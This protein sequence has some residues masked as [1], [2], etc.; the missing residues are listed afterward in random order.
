[1]TNG[2]IQDMILVGCGII[3]GILID[4]LIV[5][6]RNARHRKRQ[7]AMREAAMYRQDIEVLGYDPRNP[8]NGGGRR[9]DQDDAGFIRLQ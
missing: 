5:S 4:T 8:I 6:V 1:M 2:M 3:C 9:N 7:N